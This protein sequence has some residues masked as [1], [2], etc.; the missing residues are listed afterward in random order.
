MD[1]TMEDMHKAMAASA[2]EAAGCLRALS[3]PSRL[4]LLCKLVEG[5]RSVGELESALDL[6]QAYVSQQLARLRADG[7][8]K[9]VRDGRIVRYSLSDARVVPILE[10]LY[11]EFCS[12]AVRAQ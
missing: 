10:V 1:G 3:N 5:E 4:L 6:G 12:P 7:L 2:E 8:V 9:A 11:R